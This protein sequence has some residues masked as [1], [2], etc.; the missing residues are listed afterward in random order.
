MD[1]RDAMIPARVMEV[2][3]D[4]SAMSIMGNRMEIAG[5]RRVS[6]T[7][8]LMPRTDD[9]LIWLKQSLLENGHRVVLLPDGSPIM[10]P[11]E[12]VPAKLTDEPQANADH[13]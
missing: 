5:Q 7:L 6:M 10:H 2:K 4:F 8:E 3:V 11:S 9:E 13:W 12:C 1:M